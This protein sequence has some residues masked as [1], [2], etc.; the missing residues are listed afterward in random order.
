MPSALPG[1]DNGQQDPLQIND[2]W[3]GA[4]KQPV[5]HR[6]AITTGQ[7]AAIETN[8]EKRI[9][10]AMQ[11]QLTTTR[12][13]DAVME[14]AVDARVSQLEH[15][16]STLTD[17]LNQLAGTVTSFK[18]QQQT[19]NTQV[20][21]QVQALSAQADQQ[22]STMRNLLDQKLEEQ[23]LRIEALFTNKRSKTTPE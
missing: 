22:E 18:Q 16:V 1:I 2:P 9:R 23:M 12:K 17:N 6:G 14:P 13:E 3:A 15:Q 5:S 21:Q 10:A 4:A 7:L 11:D 8:V 20:V 19:H